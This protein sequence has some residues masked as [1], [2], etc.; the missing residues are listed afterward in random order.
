MKNFDYL[1]SVIN[2]TLL[3]GENKLLCFNLHFSPIASRLSEKNE[4]MFI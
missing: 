4:K 1:C 2:K 3:Q